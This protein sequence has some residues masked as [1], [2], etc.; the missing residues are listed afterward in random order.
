MS[1]IKSSNEEFELSGSLSQVKEDIESSENIYEMKETI[2]FI[3][4]KIDEIIVEVN[5]LKNQ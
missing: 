1:D 2:K 3:V 4:K 5:K